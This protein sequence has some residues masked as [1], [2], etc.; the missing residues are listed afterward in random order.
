MFLIKV[1]RR[2]SSPL[3]FFFWVSLYSSWIYASTLFSWFTDMESSGIWDIWVLEFHKI[4]FPVS[5]VTLI[6]CV[7]RLV[8]GIIFLFLGG[9]KYDKL[10]WW[11]SI[12]FV[13]F[14][15]EC[16]EHSKKFNEEDMKTK[17]DGKNCIVTGA[18]SGIGY[19]TAE[20]LASRC[21]SLSKFSV[22]IHF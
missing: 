4:C 12:I 10:I 1:R 6:L 22:F 15:V 7:V 16:R 5:L 11:F 9:T 14:C 17:I 20:G 19:A 18:N 13:F 8:K 3:F 2:V 21:R